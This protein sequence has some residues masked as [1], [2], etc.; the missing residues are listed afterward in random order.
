MRERARQTGIRP[1]AM[2]RFAEHLDADGYGSIRENYA[3]AVRDG[4]LGFASNPDRN[5]KAG[6][7]AYP[8]SQCE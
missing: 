4:D 7:D 6:H 5:M 1:A 8:A 3:S 2:T